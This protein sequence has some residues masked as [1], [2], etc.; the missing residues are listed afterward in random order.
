MLA[1]KESVVSVFRDNHINQK[2]AFKWR[3]DGL[4]PNEENQKEIGLLLPVDQSFHSLLLGATGSTEEKLFLADD[5]ENRCPPLGSHGAAGE[6]SLHSR[7]D[8]ATKTKKGRSVEE[9]GLA[10]KCRHP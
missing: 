2:D 3:I 9:L 5:S 7:R 10:Y 8:A 4:C 6:T 1:S